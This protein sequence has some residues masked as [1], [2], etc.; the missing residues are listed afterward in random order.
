MSNSNKINIAVIGATGYTGLDLIFMLSKHPKI[1]FKNLCATKNLGKK[2]DFFDKR[3]KRK[4]P[5]ITSIKKIIWHKLDLVFLSL[6]GELK[7]INLHYYKNKIMIYLLILELMTTE[8]MKKIYK[9][10]KLINKLYS[11]PE[12]KKLY[13]N[14]E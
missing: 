7:I 12:F 13:K 2:I 5:K 9:A 3:I 14:L 8:Y 4:L 1:K 6:N 11:I 10:K